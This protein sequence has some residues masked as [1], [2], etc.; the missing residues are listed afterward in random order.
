MALRA[1]TVSIRLVILTYSHSYLH[2]FPEIGTVPVM[3][4]D[5]GMSESDS[6]WPR[7]ASGKQSVET[8]IIDLPFRDTQ[9]KG[10]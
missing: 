7:P 5:G 10:L 6:S 9:S 2:E 4:K 1:T 3:S 8:I